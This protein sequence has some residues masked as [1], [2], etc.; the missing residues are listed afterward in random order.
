MVEKRHTPNAPS[1]LFEIPPSPLK[2]F[3]LI[4]ESK[5]DEVKSADKPFAE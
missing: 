4:C 3:V 1:P 2:I 5:I